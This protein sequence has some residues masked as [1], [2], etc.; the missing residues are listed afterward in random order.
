M[1]ETLKELLNAIK[2]GDKK[3]ENRLRKGLEKLGM[4]YYTQNVLLKELKNE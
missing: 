1:E 4:D 3:E 2:N